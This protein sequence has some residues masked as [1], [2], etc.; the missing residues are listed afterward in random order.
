MKRVITGAR[1][2]QDVRD[3]FY[4]S[5]P[6]HPLQ[7]SKGNIDLGDKVEIVSEK[8]GNLL[9]IGLVVEKGKPYEECR[10]VHITKRFE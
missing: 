9:A 2:V 7:S 10:T 6:D 8:S 1:F 5:S 4:F 3:Q